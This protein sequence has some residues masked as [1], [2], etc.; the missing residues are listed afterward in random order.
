M[1]IVLYNTK[2]KK[3]DHFVPLIPGQVSMYVCGV[4]VYDDCHLGHARSALTFD[5]IRRYLEFSGYQVTYV[6]NF[7]D[8]DDKILNRA[9]QE[10]VP[11]NDISERY[12]QNFYRDMSA[13]G[14]TKPSAEP[15][16]TEHMQDILNMVE[17]L[18]QKGMAYSIEGDV[19]FSVKKFSDYGQLSGKNLDDLQAGARIEVDARKQDPMDFALWKAS[20]PGE[21]GWDSPWGKGRPGWHIECS[22]MSVAELG[23]TFDIHGGGKD[24]IFPHHENE[25]AQS[26]AYTGKEFARY[27]VHNGFVTVDKEKMS[28]SLGNFFTIREIFDKSPVSDA[29]AITGECLRYY[30]LSTHYRSDLNFSELSLPEAKA[31]MDTI[32]GLIQRLEEVDSLEGHQGEEDWERISREFARKFQESMDDDFNTPKGLG[33]F[34]EFRGEVNKLLVKGLSK[35]TKANVIETFR[36]YGKPLGLFQIPAWFTFSVEQNIPEESRGYK[37]EEKQENSWIEELIRL[38]NEARAKKDFATAD[39]IRHE[40]DEKKITLEDRPDGTTRWKR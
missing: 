23:P 10:D 27:W 24:L 33:V 38:R 11:W 28:K 22:A 16:A 39:K 5:M 20:K 9:K 4:T 17:G 25:I 34:H 30:L 36:K 21:P 15:R 35:E 31:A 8:I 32:Y 6:R 13:L 3:K 26:C 1:S 2:T 40:L 18:V 7:T 29:E 12:I 14:I 19:Y 37:Q